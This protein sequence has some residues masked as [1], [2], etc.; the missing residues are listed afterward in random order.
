MGDGNLQ[1]SEGTRLPP[2]S[3]P[4]GRSGAFGALA[5]GIAGTF[6]ASGF[7]GVYLTGVLVGAL[8]PQPRRATLGFHE[9]LANAAEIGLFLLLGLF[10]FPSR[11]P[12]VALSGLL[13]AIVLT[14]V[15]RPV[16]VWMV[17]I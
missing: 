2:G 17:P 12:P 3:R 8:L 15:A 9:A 6:G 14:V 4:G 16:A 5:Y 11:L 10:V 7:V 13:V 1:P